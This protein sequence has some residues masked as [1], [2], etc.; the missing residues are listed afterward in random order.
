MNNNIILN[1]L[2]TGELSELIKN[3]IGSYYQSNRNTT[4]DSLELLTVNEVAALLKISRVTVFD[5]KKRG[6]LPFHRIGKQVRF[7]KHEVLEALTAVG[8]GE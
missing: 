3:A 8:G 7:K 6:V 1:G 5:W 4:D 2:S